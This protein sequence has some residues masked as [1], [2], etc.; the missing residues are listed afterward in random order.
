MDECIDFLGAARV[1]STLDDNAGYSKIRVAE[2]KE[3]LTA[4]KCHS[5]AWQCVRLPFGLCNAPTPFQSSM[6]MIL[7]RVKWKICLV[8][9]DDV[10]VF[11]SSPEEHL[12]RL[13]EVLTRPGK[14]AVTLK[15]AKCD[16]FQEEVDYLGHVITT[17]RVHVL[18]KNLRALRGLWYPETQTQMNSFLGMCGV[19]RLIVA[20]F[21]KIEKPLTVLTSTKLPKRL[22]FPREKEKKAF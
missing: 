20:D 5:G 6:D 19:Y 11:S 18:E 3:H 4:S 15:E 8:F 1:F 21:S 7:A 14:A 2:E 12:Q 10:I 22:P 13:D 9:L 16:V 17:G